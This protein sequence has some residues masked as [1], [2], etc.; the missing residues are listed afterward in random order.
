M[1]I[2][3]QAYDSKNICF[4]IYLT[5]ENTNKKKDIAPRKWGLRIMIQSINRVPDSS[6]GQK[7]A[8]ITRMKYYYS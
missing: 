5:F 8:C 7:I 1:E 2:K 4:L 3:P 6:T